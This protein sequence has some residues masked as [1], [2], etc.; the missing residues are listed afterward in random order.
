MRTV[1]LLL[2]A[3]LNGFSHDVITTRITFDREIIRLFDS[4]CVSCHHEG[5]AGFSLETYS[6]ARP[7]AKAIAEEVLTRRMPPWGAVKGF[8]DFRNDQS[9]TPE[10]LELIVNWVEGGAPE[11]EPKDLPPPPKFSP[12]PVPEKF[13]GEVIVSGDMRLTKAMLLGGLRPVSVDDDAAFQITA[14][15]PNGSIVPLLWLQNYRKRFDHPFPLRK[16]LQLP[17]RTLITG[18]P[19]GAS[20]ALVPEASIPVSEPA[21]GSE[22]VAN[23]VTAHTTP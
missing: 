5:G 21:P 6:V 17:A 19:A 8:G 1:F 9:L 20:I 15:L 16:P 22:H 23:A 7:W 4:H 2:A 18:V 3:S 10:Q 12:V 11:G 13:A 14:E